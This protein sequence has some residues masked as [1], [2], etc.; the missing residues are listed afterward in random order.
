M[1]CNITSCSVLGVDP[2]PINVEV[3]VSPGLP[4]FSVVGSPGAEIKEAKDRVFTALKNSG[5]GAPLSKIT[6]NLYPADLRK[7]GTGLDLPIAVGIL[8]SSGQLKTEIIR[9]TWM[10][11]ELGLNGEVKPVKGVL[12]VVAKAS[13]LGV[14]NIIVPAGNAGEATLIRGINILCATDISSVYNYLKDPN[15]A[16]L[17]SPE[18]TDDSESDDLLSPEYDFIQVSGQETAKRASIISAAGFHSMLM[19][20]PPGVGKSLIAKCI[21]GILPP[22]SEKEKIEMTTIMSV[23]GKLSDKKALIKSRGFE[24]PHHSITVHGLLGG[25]ATP[26]PGAVT[27]A[28]R[29]VLFLDELTEFDRHTLD[30]LRQ[31]IEDKKVHISRVNYQV[32]F[33]ADFLL[34]CAMNPCPCGYYPDRNKC[35]CTEP[36]IKRYLGKISG[37]VLDRIDLCVEMTPIKLSD[38]KAGNN[39]MS[40]LEMRQKVISARNMQKKRYANT[41]YRFNS[42]LKG[43]DIEKY[44]H[45]GEKEKALAETLYEKLSLSLRSYHR[46]LRISRT[47]ADLDESEE[48]QIKHLYEAASF[49]PNPSY[50]QKM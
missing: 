46:M 50:W 18:Y 40:S 35:N 17:D 47:L 48:I 19:S 26:K 12:P 45:L 2:I 33:P 44:C 38:M 37:P 16:P 34:V 14:K 1:Y 5:L 4:S 7:D 6:V 36:E 15:S 42:E 29:S 10:I 25:G 20:G 3:D 8:I 22:L 39:T 41:A 23:A 43:S 21:P 32:E 28:H 30:A 13:S 49:R 9:D 24:A 27:L 11:G 31:P